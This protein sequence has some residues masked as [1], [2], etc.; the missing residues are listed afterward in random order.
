MSDTPPEKRAR[1]EATVDDAKPVHFNRG[2]LDE[3]FI[4]KFRTA[5][6]DAELAQHTNVESNGCQA[7]I[8]A[9][10]FHTGRL[11]SVFSAEFLRALRRE[12]A[13][14]TWHERA[15]D[16]YAF[17]Q[18]DDLALNTNTHIRALRTY[19]AGDEFVAFMEQ[20]TGVQLTRGHLD[21]AAQR[22][23]PT[24]HLLCHDD[25]VQRGK[26]TRKIAYIIYLTEDWAPGDGG[27]LGLFAQDDCGNP[28]EVVAR[29]VPEFNSLGFFLTGHSSYHTVEE[30]TSDDRERWSVTGWFYGPAE[31]DDMPSSD[32]PKSVM[33][34]PVPLLEHT[35]D[36][37]RWI[38]AAYLKPQTQAQIQDSFVEQSSTEL[39]DFLRADVFATVQTEVATLWASATE[40]GPAHVCK[41]LKAHATHEAAPVTH[42][43]LQFLQS[44]QFACVL[45]SVTSLDL[46][47]ASQQVRRFDRGH[48]T[49][50]HD[51]A[52]DPAGLDVV[53]SLSPAEWIDTWGGSTHY[54]A[55]ADELL[56]VSPQAN[57]LSIVMRDDGT[58]RFVKYVNHTAQESRQEISM[59]F[60]EDCE[61]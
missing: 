13:G 50:V 32:L 53:L 38:N 33:V 47:R 16:L 29:L 7:E 10:P 44:T 2:F 48:Y 45:S 24:N 17:H 41:Y 20:I 25:D 36:P 55:D 60:I 9:Q 61:E 1:T 3:Q 18:T 58:L 56:S 43:L 40:Q 37:A 27:A 8:M 14:L 59:L 5:F 34:E 39:R 46:V 57:S 26:L 11:H 35:C 23:K 51:Q 31:T 52:L 19:L 49:L 54:V 12:L 15:N 42:E 4:S 6:T 28:T 21:L 22:Y 30:V